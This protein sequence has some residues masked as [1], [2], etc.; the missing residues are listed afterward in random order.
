MSGLPLV[1][2]GRELTFFED[3]LIHLPEGGGAVVV[4]GEAGIGK[5]S[6]L[7]AVRTQAAHHGLAM[8]TTSG[9]QSEQHVAFAAL[10]R[11]LR[12]VLP[13]QSRLP[14]PQRSAL[15]AAFGLDDVVAPDFFLVALA[16]LGLLSEAAADAPLLLVV[17]DAEWLDAA[18]SDVL[19]FVSRRLELEAIL[20]LF[21][22]R[23]GTAARIHSAGLPQLEL[24][25]LDEDSS[26]ELLAANFPG[27][28]DSDRL[29]VIAEARGNPLALVELPRAFGSGLIPSADA[30]LPLTERLE[31]AFSADISHLPP[32]VR[33]LLL[34][35]ALDDGGDQERILN[36]ASIVEGRSVG[37]GE[38]SAARASGAI[39]LEGDGWRFRHPLVRSA[40]YQGSFAVQRRAAHKA[41]ASVY[42]DDPDRGTWHRVAALAGPDD[43]VSAALEEL[44]ERA[45][46]RGAPAIA[47]TALERA[48]QLSTDDSR[49][50]SLLVRS[51]C[52]AFDIGRRDASSVLARDAQ[53]LELAPRE[54]TMLRYVLELGQNTA[55]TG[56]AGIRSLV[57]IAEQLDAVGESARAMDALLEGSSR[58]WWGNADQAMRDA[59]LAAAQRL[60]FPPDSPMQLVILAQSDPVNCGRAVIEAIKGT[61]RDVDDP[62]GMHLI[63]LAA[64]AVWAFDLGLAFLSTAV[65]GLRAQHRLGLLAR[66]LVMQA[67]AAVHLARIPLAVSAAEEG[68]VLSLETGQPQWAAAAHLAKAAVAAE[69]GDFETA[70]AQLHEADNAIRPSAGTPLLALA[71]LVRGR[72]AVAHQQYAVGFDYL[73]RTLDP[74][75]PTYHPFIGACGLPDLV[76][77]AALT[78]RLDLAAEFLAQLESIAAQTSAPFLVATAGYARPLVSAD[79]AAESLY[80]A[81]LGSDLTDWPVY[82]GRMLLWYGRWL[83]RQR[84]VAESRAHLHAALNS[85]DA[86]A[87]PLLAETARQE[88]RA[89]GERP[90]QRIAEAWSTLTPQE[91]QIARM[92]STGNT[93]R[94][95]AQRLYLSP[96]TVQ[97]HLYRIFPKLGITER[98]QLRDAFAAHEMI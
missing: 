82:R 17:E 30:P 76:E 43:Q 79:D 3:R 88:L 13:S 36:A 48:S 35:A 70:E 53:R 25:P 8:L 28:P 18:T 15:E 58:C 46:R 33:T 73:R 93:N 54:R 7:D 85:F 63:G 80:E 34:V 56:T 84:R 87:F 69:R 1:G 55:W 2:R 81:A 65:D 72:G 38:L 16:S 45:V 62:I 39:V 5:S 4:S 64:N 51:A 23:N 83:R 10:Q 78:G 52:L 60:S 21:A 90:A 41:L 20:V 37:V 11:L 57:D 29:R 42:N 9:F 61:A 40:V 94:E 27:L 19:A 74:G 49:R 92:A 67:W 24:E 47:V 98:H 97:S 86:L 12:P 71:Q 14:G 50:G 95:I 89:S 75:D 59:V 68:R 96:R 6:L 77:A 91:L 44:A 66:S 31:G 22:V 26:A 32:V